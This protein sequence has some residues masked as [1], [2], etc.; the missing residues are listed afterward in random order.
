[1]RTN[2]VLD[3]TL[4][5]EAQRLTCIRSKRDVV[6][7]ALQELVRLRHEQQMPKLVFFQKYIN[8][9]I[10]SENFTPLTRNEIY[11]T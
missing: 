1:M 4:I 5:K 10:V 7:F 3:A 2:I 9:P 11:S 8:Q 6:N